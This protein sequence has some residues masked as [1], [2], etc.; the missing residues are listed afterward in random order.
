MK[1]IQVD[2]FDRDNVSD[3]FIAQHLTTYWAEHIVT[4]LNVKFLDSSLFFKAVPDDYKLYKFV[5]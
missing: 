5:P 1:I 3:I 2:A 4:L